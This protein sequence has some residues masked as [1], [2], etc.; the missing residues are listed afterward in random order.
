[1]LLVVK[2]RPFHFKSKKHKHE[3]RPA[4]TYLAK[5][6]KLLRCDAVSSCFSSEAMK[7]HPIREFARHRCVIALAATSGA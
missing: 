1:M 2:A 3:L 4:K 7:C 5:Y 6:S